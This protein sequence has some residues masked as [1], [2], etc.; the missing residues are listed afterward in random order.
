[1]PQA[2]DR[3]GKKNSTDHSGMRHHV[4]VQFAPSAILLI[5]KIEPTS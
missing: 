5:D 4:E 3:P 1:M 2:A